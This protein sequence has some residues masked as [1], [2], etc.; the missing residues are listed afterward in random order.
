MIMNAVVVGAQS[1][2]VFSAEAGVGAGRKAIT[3]G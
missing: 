2:F 3:T 1:F